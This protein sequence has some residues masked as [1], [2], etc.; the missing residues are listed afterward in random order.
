VNERQQQFSMTEA[1]Q[2]ATFYLGGA[3]AV[4][5]DLDNYTK[6]TVAD[7]KRVAAKYLTPANS[8]LVTVVPDP[9]KQRPTP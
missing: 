2:H 9:S 5:T 4:F 7:I 3:E 6:V 1:V 8:M